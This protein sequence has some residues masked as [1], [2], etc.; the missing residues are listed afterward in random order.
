MVEHDIEVAGVVVV[1]VGQ[2]DPPH[3]LGV[4]D[5][6]RLLEPGVADNAEPVST[7]I[8]S[9]PRITR[10]WAPKR[11]PVGESASVGISHVSAATGWAVV[12]STLSCIGV[13]SFVGI[14][15]VGIK[16]YSLE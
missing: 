4:D 3:V 16:P 5:R 1:V 13:T 11:P 15:L 2:E 12:G 8:G 10:L 6:E 7:S 14:Q 9:R